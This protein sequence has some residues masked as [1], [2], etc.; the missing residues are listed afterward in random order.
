MTQHALYPRQPERRTTN[1]PVEL[2]AAGGNGRRIGGMAAVFNSPSQDLGGFIEKV[3]FR[4]MN[5]SR[6]DGFPGVVC[7]YD[8][9]NSMLLGTIQADT[10]RLL[11]DGRG[12][13]YEVDVPES[14][15]DVLELVTRGDIANS[16][17]AFQCFEDDWTLDA[18]GM[19]L[20]TLVSLRLIDVAPVVT[21]AYKDS[22]VAGLRS[23]ARFVGAP[24]ED[25]VARAETDELRG[26]FVRTDNRGQ[27][28]EPAKSGRVTLAGYDALAQITARRYGPEESKPP[29]SGRVAL[30]ESLA[31]RAED[32][33]KPTKSGHQALA[34]MLGKR[35]G[36]T[37]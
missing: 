7:R 20:R 31:N 12:L 33:I 36:P 29:K 1:L 17:F 6:G 21:P 27:R 35:W 18:D 26:F 15:D 19:P 16:S 10:L 13:H 8:H 28:Q 11:V 24:Y 30:L 23:M 37:E 5:K 14:R 2:R 22:T 32:P 3:G 34:E 4:A 9:D 25:V